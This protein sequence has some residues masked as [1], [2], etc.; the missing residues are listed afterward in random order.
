M[1]LNG[2]WLRAAGLLPGSLK[3]IFARWLLG[4]VAML[5]GTLAGISALSTGPAADPYFSDAP[6]PLPLLVFIEFVGRL[7]GAMWGLLALGAIVAWLANQW[8]TAG[9]ATILDRHLAGRPRVWRTTIDVGKQYLGR[10][11]RVAAFAG[12][13][14]VIALALTGRAFDW[15]ADHGTLAGWSGETLLLTLPITRA[16]VL[17]AV[18]S[19]VG[20]AGLWCRVI[21]VRGARRCVRR[22]HQVVPRLAWRAPV[23]GFLLPMLLSAFSLVA[24]ALVVFAWRQSGAGALGLWLPIWLAVLLGQAYVWHWRLRICVELAEAGLA[25]AWSTVP[26][27]PWHVFRRLWQFLKRRLGRLRAA[28]HAPAPE[29]PLPT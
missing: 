5:P 28:G 27:T 6:Q 26:D 8:L 12:V 21:L 25:T 2:A 22:L 7:P 1:A 4:I 23:Q 24:A 15:L 3:L 18:A 19:A 10:Y 17:L 11:L 13:W 9:A 29:T 14:L 16:L 20:A